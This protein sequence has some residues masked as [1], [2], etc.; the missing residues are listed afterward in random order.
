MS[1]KQII[2]KSSGEKE[3]FEVEKLK[4][5]LSRSGADEITISYVIDE[6]LPTIS[7]GTSTKEIYKKAF[8]VLRKEKSTS[9]ARYSLKKAIMELGPTGYTF[10]QFIGQ[11]LKEQGFD[12]QVGV[13]VQG[14]CVQHE[15]DVVAT[16]GNK[17]YLVECKFYNAQGK[18]ANV[19]VPLYIRS[20]V[21]DIVKK[22]QALP[23]Y[24]D[25]QF[26][27]WIVTNTRFTGDAA[28]Y[29]RCAGLHLMGWDYPESHSLKDMIEKN[30]LFPITVLTSLEKMYKQILLSK[31]YVLCKQLLHQPELLT[32]IGIK[33]NKQKAIMEELFDLSMLDES[34]IP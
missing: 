33:A 16:S 27:G 2:I 32:Q 17:Q 3:E 24:K 26:Y 1:K 31:G 30:G 4:S 25:M 13:N 12:V 14:Q 23:E 19:Q 9:A 29:G 18:Y 8:N 20:R 28:D 5:S 10:E 15:V 22:R 21:D 34:L 6:I 11:L 7:D